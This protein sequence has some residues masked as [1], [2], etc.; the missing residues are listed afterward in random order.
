[1]RVARPRTRPYREAERRQQ[2]RFFLLTLLVLGVVV[3]LADGLRNALG[4]VALMLIG[5]A[6]LVWW[7]R[8]QR[9]A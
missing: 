1:M 2:R 7:E 6:V 5:L 3:Y 8:R 4:A 9:R